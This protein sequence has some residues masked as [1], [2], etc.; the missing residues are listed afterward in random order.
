[1]ASHAKQKARIEESVAHWMQEFGFLP[2]NTVFEYAGKG[3]VE[4]GDAG[5]S[6]IG[7]HWN[8]PYRTVVFKVFPAALECDDVELQTTLLHEMMHLVLWRLRHYR[9]ASEAIFG[10]LEEEA[11]DLLSYV[12]AGHLVEK[13]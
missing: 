11:A 4:I 9:K 8:Y 1:M 12:L 10:D 2:M 13:E 5:E 6:C 7:V 3:E